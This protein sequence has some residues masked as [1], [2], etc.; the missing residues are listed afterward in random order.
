MKEVRGGT[1][2]ISED[3][4]SQIMSEALGFEKGTIQV[5][6]ITGEHFHRAFKVT[7]TSNSE[8]F[9]RVAEGCEFPVLTPSIETVVTHRRK[10]NGFVG[11]QDA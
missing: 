4:F 11:M 9:P 1:F 2:V 3:M 10:F 7:V 5:R 8:L 6:W